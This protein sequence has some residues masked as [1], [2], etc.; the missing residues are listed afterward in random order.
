MAVKVSRDDIIA[1]RLHAQHL[2]ERLGEQGL[3]DAAG[4]CGVQNSPPGSAL[5]ALHARVRNLSPDRVDE[6]IARDKSMMQSWCMRGSPFYFPTADAPVFT[7]GVLPPT[8]EAMR[9]FVLGVGPAVDK[10]GL[11][12]T[13]TVDLTGA[14]IGDVL[15]GRRLAVDE[16]GAELAERI[17]R[18][19]SKK[20][21]GIWEQEGPHAAGQPLGEAVVHFCIRILTLRRVICFAPREGNKAPF[22]LVDEW[23]G[24]PIPDT[25]PEAARADLLRRYLRCYGPSTRADFAAWLGVRAGDAV[26]WWTLVEDEMTPVEFG[27]K[28]WILTEDLDALRSPPTPKG[29][30]LLPPRDPY[31]QL[32]DRETV[33]DKKHHRDVWKTVGDP[34]TALA[35]G[36]II[37]VWRPRK[38]GRRLT[39]TIKTFDALPA[40]T[41]KPLQAEADQVATLRGATSVDVEF[42]TY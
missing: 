14:E 25:D 39:V 22:V 33:L 38:S 32:R 8:E 11:S 31:T 12:L 26:P 6:A 23:L 20:Q 13:E 9:Q 4:A 2:T 30:R 3:L 1:F 37:G 34:G 29:V 40:R 35:D 5:L 21:R 27:R 15:R 18:K 41:K 42:D 28:T 7:T 17:A 19:L 36:E 16:L 24:K 10:L